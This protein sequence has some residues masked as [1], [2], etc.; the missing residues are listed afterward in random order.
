MGSLCVCVLGPCRSLGCIERQWDHGLLSNLLHILSQVQ[1]GLWVL[2]YVVSGGL[3]VL[4]LWAPG[5][6]PQSYTLQVQEEDQDIERN[7][8]YL[9]L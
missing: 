8:V 2:R 7:Q 5:L 1:F 3:F 6:R 9:I 4:G